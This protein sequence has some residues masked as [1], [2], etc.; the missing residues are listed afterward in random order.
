MRQIVQQ[1]GESLFGDLHFLSVS[2]DFK[3]DTVKKIN[4]FWLLLGYFLYIFGNFWDTF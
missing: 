2:F 1:C 3:R 4:T